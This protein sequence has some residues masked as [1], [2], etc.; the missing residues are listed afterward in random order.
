[1]VL[2]I[3]FLAISSC[4]VSVTVTNPTKQAWVEAP[5]VI[6]W[7]DEIAALGAKDLVLRGTEIHPIQVDDLDGDGKPD[8]LV[9]LVSIAPEVSKEYT[10][11]KNQYN[12]DSPSRAFTGMYVK[13]FEGP[14]WESDRLAFRLYWDERNAMD[15]FCK[16]KPVLGL[17]EYAKPEVNY[18]TETPWGM[19]VL[20]VGQA[21]GAGG[22]G[23][24]V[25]GAVQKVSKTDRDYKVVVNGPLRAI[26]DL[27]YTNWVVGERKFDLLVRMSMIA[28]QKWST[29][30]LWLT[31]QDKEPAPEFVTGVVKHDETTLLQSREYGF[32]GRWGLQALGPGEV[33]KGSH[34]GL[35]VVVN[36]QH[37][38]S[39]GEDD[40]N[41][42]IRFKGVTP[43]KSGAS[44]PSNTI[45]GCYKSHASWIH[46]PGGATSP[47]SY[48]AMLLDL[49]RL[50]PRVD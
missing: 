10:I 28:G 19:D 5:V 37:I 6:P 44:Q 4:A 35:G 16:R 22:F 15:V 11:E 17:A 21:L 41:S 27:Q 40:V 25:D 26:I 18:H 12:F 50:Q 33:P 14:G 38:V 31:P 2:V 8:E 24:W 3:S 47:E 13:G 45:Y 43:P 46:E 1:M 36:P 34:L 23:I 7:T 29:A 42:Y 20:K 32:V 39:I 30:E 49:A 48:E 9:F